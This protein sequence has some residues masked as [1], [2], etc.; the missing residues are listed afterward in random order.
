MYILPYR[1]NTLSGPEWNNLGKLS[2]S[3]QPGRLSDNKNDQIML[4][5]L[6]QNIPLSKEETEDSLISN[7]NS[8]YIEGVRNIYN[9][10]PFLESYRNAELI[11]T[12]WSKM[13]NN[14]AYI[15]SIDQISIAIEDFHAPSQQ[16]LHLIANDATKRITN[17][18]HILIHCFG[19]LGRTGSVI[20]AIC[21]K[22]YNQYN[23]K[24]AIDYVRD[25]YNKYA[26]E[27]PSQEYALEI[28]GKDLQSLD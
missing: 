28:F 4:N 20:A 10:I 3:S 22:L 9:L 18:E 11:G 1:Y 6:K 23:Y 17:G 8:L 2:G 21:M 27:T 16:Q 14:T 19:G 13:F 24:D 7:L 15:S 26:V 5:K 25:K 12:L